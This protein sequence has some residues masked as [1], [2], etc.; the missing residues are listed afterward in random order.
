M[1]AILPHQ[2]DMGQQAG[3]AFFAPEKMLT[4]VIAIMSAALALQPYSIPY[5]EAALGALLVGLTAV[6]S[7]AF[8][9]IVKIE[10][11]RGHSAHLSDIAQI[12]DNTAPILVF[13]VITALAVFGAGRFGVAWPSLIRWTMASCVGVVFAL[14]F[15]SRYA[16]DGNVMKALK[17]AVSWTLLGGLLYSAKL[18][19]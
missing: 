9:D 14:G 5:D 2:I 3:T 11:E 6:S 17:R 16:T 18:L 12:L 10:A 4:G 7:S 15:F 13:P 19:A 1:A 8:N